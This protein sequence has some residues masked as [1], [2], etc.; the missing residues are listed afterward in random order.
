MIW[1][2]TPRVVVNGKN[3]GAW[4]SRQV[5]GLVSDGIT[6][7]CS[8]VKMITKNILTTTKNIFI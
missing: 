8:N 7:N 1:K 4:M 5:C 3:G 2:L 6:F